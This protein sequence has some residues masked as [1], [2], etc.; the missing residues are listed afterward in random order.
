M[1]T[2]THAMLD[3]LHIGN[4]SI[5]LLAYNP[6]GVDITAG[7]DFS[8]ADQIFTLED[9]FQLSCDDPSSSDI[10]I[11][12]HREVIDVAIDKG[13]NWV[14]TG[15]IPS[16]AV[17]VLE[18]FFPEGKQIAGGTAS[19]VKGVTGADG[20]AF[21]TGEGFLATPEIIE[22]SVL[23]ESESKNTAILFPH[24]KMIV[25]KPKKDDNSN[26]AYLTFTGYV[27]PNPAKSSGD[28]VGDFA[29]LK[30]ATRPGNS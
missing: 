15:N 4:A 5:S 27:L 19:S 14:M 3:D 16:I 24:V 29:V 21:Y 1:A 18:Y 28:Y 10:R 11:D 22:V 8:A 12:Q 30:A 13:G 23:A 26:P 6:N 25:S 7:M 9:T 17:A 20:T 2:L